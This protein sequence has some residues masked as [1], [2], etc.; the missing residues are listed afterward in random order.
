[1]A[2]LASSTSTGVGLA[3]G[4]IAAVLV[5]SAVFY[6]IGRGEDRDRA[7]AQRAPEAGADVVEAGAADVGEA[8]DVGDVAEVA[9]VA[10]ACGT[11]SRAPGSRLPTPSRRRR[12][13]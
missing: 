5:I 9:D 1:M 6:V 7:A 12:R 8:D 3:L 2:Q 4:G 13:R 10:E 11:S